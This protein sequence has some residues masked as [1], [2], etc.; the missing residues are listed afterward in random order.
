MKRL[1]PLFFCLISLSSCAYVQTHRNVEESFN[2]YDGSSLEL[3]LYL[4]QVGQQWYLPA[5][6]CEGGLIK[7]YPSVYDSVLL[8]TDN[9]PPTWNTEAGQGRGVIVYYPISSGTATVLMREDGYATLDLLRDELQ[10][11]QQSCLRQLPAG[12]RKHAVL[13]HIQS[14]DEDSVYLIGEK[15]QDGGNRSSVQMFVWA[16]RL[17]V[18]VPLTLA[19]HA[20]IP[21]MAP[22]LFFKEFFNEE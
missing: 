5:Y 11:R 18:D 21:L 22:V 12:A 1:L 14:S 13:A 7:H 16:D 10:Q 4:V 8:K 15:L 17:L 3:P 19:Y 6:H 9:I 20:A 2:R